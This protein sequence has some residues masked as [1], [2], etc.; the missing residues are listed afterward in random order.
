MDEK[1]LSDPTPPG[2]ILSRAE[3][4]ARIAGIDD[5]RKVSFYSP[6]FQIW[7]RETEEL[8]VRMF[9]A[10]SSPTANFQAILFTPLFLSC[11]CGDTVF[12]EAYEKGL[13]EASTLLASH[14]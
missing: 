11:R 5:L 6:A 7:H 3:L 13:E 12:T 1:I 8:L 9:G 4:Q 14:Q 10:D 2:K